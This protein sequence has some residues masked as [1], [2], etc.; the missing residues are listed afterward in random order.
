TLNNP[1]SQKPNPNHLT[2]W[3]LGFGQLG[4]FQIIILLFPHH[5][6]STIRLAL[7]IKAWDLGIGH[8]GF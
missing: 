8:L 5:S 7:V 1:K 6:P 4:F 2:N 3:N